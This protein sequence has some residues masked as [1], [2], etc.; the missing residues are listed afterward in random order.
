MDKVTST[1]PLTFNGPL[2]AGLRAVALLGAAFPREYDLQ[3]LTAF[4]YLL[5]NTSEF[6]G[7]NNLHP[8]SPIHA[9]ATQVRRA[10]VQ[11][12]IELMMTRD[13][14]SRSADKNGIFFR[15][16]ESA[17]MF[18][19]SLQSPYLSRVKSYASWLVEHLG[20]QDDKAFEAVMRN[21]F[22]TWLMEFQQA[23]ENTGS[24]A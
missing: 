20:H 5:L 1:A 6:G 15:A 8:S 4:D 22:D 19:D 21:S 18:L 16:G 9:P 17:A 23:S 7:P 11:E 12:G 2:E 24:V 14:I 13:L 10:V 3:R